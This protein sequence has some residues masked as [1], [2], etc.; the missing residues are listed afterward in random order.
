MPAGSDRHE[1]QTISAERFVG[2]QTRNALSP[3]RTGGLVF[4]TS[5]SFLI[6]H[7]VQRLAGLLG[8]LLGKFDQ[9]FLF[10]FVEYVPDFFEQVSDEDLLY[11]CCIPS[12]CWCDVRDLGGS[13]GL[14][15]CCV[16]GSVAGENRVR[17]KLGGVGDQSVLVDVAMITQVEL[18]RR[19]TTIHNAPQ[20]ADCCLE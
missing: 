19:E 11:L 7:N 2:S 16:C 18:T 14:R 8:C 1:Q 13:Q 6:H 5:H 15:T 20:F 9:R 17:R 10:P 4:I 12:R 3:V